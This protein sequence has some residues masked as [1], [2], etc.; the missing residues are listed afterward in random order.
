MSAD[1]FEYQVTHQQYEAERLLHD[2]VHGWHVAEAG[3][4]M[5]LLAKA[6]AAAEAWDMERRV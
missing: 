5:V 2:V 1:A 6:L 3:G 4:S